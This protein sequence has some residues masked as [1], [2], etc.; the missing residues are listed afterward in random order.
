MFSK[1]KS[2]LV[3]AGLLVGIIVISLAA[4]RGAC[5]A[6]GATTCVEVTSTAIEFLQKN[7]G[8]KID[9]APPAGVAVPK[10]P[11]LQGEPAA[12]VVQ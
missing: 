5:D 3:G 4:V 6:V 8:T 12:P 7:S 2:F 11:E 10:A 9:E 1:F